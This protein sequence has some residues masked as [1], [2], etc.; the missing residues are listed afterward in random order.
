MLPQSL[1]AKT[2]VA[3]A[4]PFRAPLAPVQQSRGSLQVCSIELMTLML[5]R[6]SRSVRLST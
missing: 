2:H 1:S 5:I 4:T 3:N 6:W